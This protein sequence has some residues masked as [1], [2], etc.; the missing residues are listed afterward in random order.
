[1]KKKKVLIIDDDISCLEV[2]EIII[3]D[4]GFETF[5][6]TTWKSDTIQE[7]INIIPDLIILDEWLVG[8]KGSEICVILKSVNQLRRIPVVLVSG[9]NG[10]AE[11]A[12]KSFADGY[13]EKP[14]DIT[15]V[16]QMVMKF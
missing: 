12:K 9:T 1:M 15:D 14:F 4:L 3:N 13:I 10:L 11:I 5:T 8:V 6:F 16:E 7:I 2:M